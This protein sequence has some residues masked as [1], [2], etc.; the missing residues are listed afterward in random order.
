MILSHGHI[1]HVGCLDQFTHCPILMART[2]RAFD[3]PRYFFDA[4]PLDWPLA[5]YHLIDADLDI[6]TGLR[7]LMTPGHAPGHLSAMLTLPA[8]GA[9]LLTA[10]AISRPAEVDEGFADAWNPELAKTSAARILEMAKATNALV[11]YGHSPDQ[12]PLLRKIPEFYR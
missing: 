10:D 5:D 4:R 11:I 1:D 8:T 3:R 12:W 7:V 6:C 2:E 9:V